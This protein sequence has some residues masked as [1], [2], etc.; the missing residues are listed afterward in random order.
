M[1]LGI[2]L[3]FSYMADTSKLRAN[4]RHN[5]KTE[6][7][8]NKQQATVDYLSGVFRLDH[9]VDYDEDVQFCSCSVDI[10]LKFVYAKSKYSL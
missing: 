8:C 9:I 6:H 7:F 3:G 5:V 4:E 1:P 2:S 10:L